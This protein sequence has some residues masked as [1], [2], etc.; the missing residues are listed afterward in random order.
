[1]SPAARGAP[2]V[3]LESKMSAI[4]FS[5][6]EL[7][8]IN[9]LGFWLQCGPEELYLSFAEFP[10]FEHATVAQIARVVCVSSSRLYWPELDL[11]LTV[12]AIRNR[13]APEFMRAGH[14]S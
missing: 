14:N 1:L 10:G 11:D 8:S 9:P 6:A 3:D 2:A 12:D 4:S 5:Y 13:R 7:T